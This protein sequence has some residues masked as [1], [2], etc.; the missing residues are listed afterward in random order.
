MFSS[1]ARAASA[2]PRPPRAALGRAAQSPPAPRHLLGAGRPRPLAFDSGCQPALARQ[3]GTKAFSLPKPRTPSLPMGLAAAMQPKT[4]RVLDEV[5]DYKLARYRL[6]KQIG[7]GNF[8]VV[9]EAVDLKTSDRVAVKIMDKAKFGRAMCRN[10]VDVL[11]SVNKKVNHKRLTPVLDVFEDAS[12]LYIVLELL[13][14]GE[15]FDRVSERGRLAEGEVAHIIRK[16][17]YALEALHRHG[18]LHRDIK[19]ENIVLDQEGGSDFKITDFGFATEAPRPKQQQQQQLVAGSLAESHGPLAQLEVSAGGGLARRESASAPTKRA[20]ATTDKLA[21]TLGY[22]APEVLKHQ[23]YS[24]ACDVWSTGVVMFVLLAGYAPF[25]LAHPDCVW[26]N[27]DEHV[28]AE[29]EAIETGRAP[30]AWRRSMLE[31]P[32][33]S[34][35]PEAKALVAKM[36]TLD[37]ARRITIKGVLGHAFIK[38]FTEADTYEYHDFE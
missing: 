1:L 5:T 17:A 26:K 34:I 21:G 27:M 28:R 19:L 14:G 20:I 35:S 7:A 13:R 18:I 6:G 24:P 25:P 12:H 8:A 30:D 29:L 9:H 10:E 2:V 11:F 15:L 23:L 36:L 32:W 31:S 33:S 38:R 37:P 4:F 3:V 16:L 22:C